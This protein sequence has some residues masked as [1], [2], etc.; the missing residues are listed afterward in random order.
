MPKK[1]NWTEVR[2]TIGDYALAAVDAAARGDDVIRM[3]KMFPQYLKLKVGGYC[4][5]FCRQ[6]TET[7]LEGPAFED[8]ILGWQADTARHMERKLRAR[9]GMVNGT[10]VGYYVGKTKECAAHGDIVG[11]NL[12]AS[13][14][15]GHIGIC[16]ERGGEKWIAENT[17]SKTRGKPRRAG[18]KLSRWEDMVDENGKSRVTG[19]YRLRDLGD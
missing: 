10:K 13:V 8:E 19:V 16:V 9:K 18:T 3:G 4:A 17:S 14:E 6:V 15:V 12:P 11:I 1:I 2:K 5:R 7:A